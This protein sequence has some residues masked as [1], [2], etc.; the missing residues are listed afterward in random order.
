MRR[1]KTR[2]LERMTAP[3]GTHPITSVPGVLAIGAWASYFGLAIAR[4]FD[5]PTW[6]L[7]AIAFGVLSCVAL[8]VGYR[9]WRLTVLLASSTYLLL[10]ADRV[11]NLAVSVTDVEKS[12]LFSALTFYYSTSWRV[13]SLAF[14]DRGVF[15]GSAHAFLEYVMPVLMVILIAVTLFSWAHSRRNS[16][17]G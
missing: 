4:S 11:I 5:V 14:R 13:T 8:A 16:E 10:Y 12:S 17:A 1:G 3:D 6:V 7:I 2:T 9:H 15:D